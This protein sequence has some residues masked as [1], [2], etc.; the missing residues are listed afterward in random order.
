[1]AQTAR[2]AEFDD[3][4]ESSR[5]HKWHKANAQFLLVFI[6]AHIFNHLYFLGGPGEHHHM[7]MSLRSLYRMPVIE[8]L[9]IGSFILQIVLGL[10]LASRNWRPHSRWSWA[11]VISG[12]MIALFLIQ[13]LL[14]AFYVRYFVPYV[15]TNAWWALSVVSAPPI[16][17][18]FVPYYFAGIAA[19]A[20]HLASAMHFAGGFYA[21][22]A[23]PFAIVGMLLAA[24]VVGAMIAI[25]ASEE[26]PADYQ[27]YL[28]EM[29]GL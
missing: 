3:W 16:S 19:I 24:M 18:Y 28:S 9:I 7:M 12:L 5:V 17:I 11:Q 20:I 25:N 23:K 2:S 1:M 8:A 4:R 29:F 27:R 6:A 13:H 22:I 10:I 15:D 21:R 26:I 14:A